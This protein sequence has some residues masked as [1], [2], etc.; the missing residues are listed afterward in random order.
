MK[1]TIKV[2][3]AVSTIL[4]AL[5]TLTSCKKNKDVELNSQRVIRLADQPN[6][7]PLKVAVTKGFFKDEFGDDFKFELSSF[8]N[9][10][11]INEAFIAGSLD[12]AQ[13]GD[14]P[15]VQAIAN[16]VDIKIVASFWALDEAY[17]I[18]NR[19]G[20]PV[21]ELKDLKGAKVGY[22]PGTNE[23]KLVLRYITSQGYTA[24]DVTLINV[25]AADALATL[26]R[27]DID[28]VIV[29]QPTIESTAEAAG[30]KVLAY[31]KGYYTVA[32]YNAATGKFARNN[33][34][35]LARILKVIQ[36]TEDWIYANQEEAYEIV[37]KYSG[38]TPD[39]VEQY[40]I[41]RKWV[42][43][44]S[45]NYTLEVQDTADFALS[46]GTISRKLDAKSF[47]DTSYLKKAGL[48]SE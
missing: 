19:A 42:T 47:I 27:G 35:T 32:C 30:G 10:P 11:A 41:S 22:R 48:K 2:I 6:Y 25:P 29:T 3:I 20:S 15:I 33:P 31:N 18:V 44:W 14:T 21:Q 37:A 46:Q 24:K 40:W 23:H 8:V 38:T 1:K 28:A 12:F 4:L 34:D 9:G 13:L 36:K 26:V 39:K 5:S 17:G 7:L 45:P 43:E 16:D